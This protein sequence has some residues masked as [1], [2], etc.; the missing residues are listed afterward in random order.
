MEEDNEEWQNYFLYDESS[1]T[2]LRWAVDRWSGRDYQILLVSAGEQAGTIR[3][4]GRASKVELMGR[5]IFVH[6]I[7]W[8]MHNGEIP[9]GLVIDHIDGDCLNNKIS[10][11]RLVTQALNSRNQ[12]KPKN[13]SSGTVGVSFLSP[14]GSNSYWK[15]Y[16]RDSTGK[17]QAKCFSITKL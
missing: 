9:D 5:N 2:C 1:L 8:E 7:I 4:S 12:R 15:A 13:N 16:W 6:R 10:N 14:R 3:R 17:L 11:L